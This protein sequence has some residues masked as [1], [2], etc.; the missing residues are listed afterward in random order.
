MP[1]AALS[2]RYL[3]KIEEARADFKDAVAE[4]EASKV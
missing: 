1:C 3:A 4:D 2:D